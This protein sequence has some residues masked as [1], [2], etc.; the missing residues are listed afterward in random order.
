MTFIG[1]MIEFKLTERISTNPIHQLKINYT[2]KKLLIIVLAIA[3]FSGF[4]QEDKSEREK[5]IRERLTKRA[6][7]SPKDRAQIET[8]QLALRL[9]LT[10]KQ[11]AQV[12]EILTAHHAK[13][14]EK[15]KMVKKSRKDMS[16]EEINQLKLDRLD[17]QIALKEDMKAVL[18]ADQYAKFSQMMERRMKRAKGMKKKKRKIEYIWI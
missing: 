1:L 11:Q 17:A 15:K 16:D 12:E 13:G 5:I 18:D 6:E 3:S 9:D 4:A 14:Q 10:E 7:K 8:K 2:M